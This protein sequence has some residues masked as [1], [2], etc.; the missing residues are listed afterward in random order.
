MFT[1]RDQALAHIRDY[2]VHFHNCSDELKND[3]SFILDAVK[4]VGGVLEFARSDFKND[5][6]IVFEAI[7]QDNKAIEFAN[8]RFKSDEV[9]VTK[10]IEEGC[11]ILGDITTDLKDNQSIVLAHVQKYSDSLQYASPRLKANLE[12]IKAAMTQDQY[13]IRYAIIDD[14]NKDAY[15]EEL[16]EIDPFVR[17]HFDKNDD[18]DFVLQA[19]R[20]SEKALRY[21]SK[22]LQ[23]NRYFILAA[24]KVNGLAL[25][26]A[27]DEFKNDKFIAL[28]AGQQNGEA[29]RYVGNEIADDLDIIISSVEYNPRWISKLKEEL[30]RDEEIAVAAAR[31]D[32]FTN[33]E[34]S[35]LC[36]NHRVVMT[37]VKQNGLAL[38]HGIKNNEDIVL[39][40]VK[41]N[42]EAL[43]YAHESLRENPDFMRKVN[44]IIGD[45]VTR[46]VSIFD[47]RSERH[48][49]VEPAVSVSI[50]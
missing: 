15:I 7:K 40:A 9:F 50:S 10:L 49:S 44:A 21:A 19:I 13:A 2:I 18:E 36:N 38:R 34:V 26:F 31:V 22:R 48:V 16:I 30:Y 43:Q 5:E 11:Y 39:E 3:R 14:S 17:L 1:D 42:P 46:P 35:P 29:F 33:L 37:A 32:G 28:R 45:T 25:K 27:I 4:L 23:T 47:D 6:E 8:D 41:Q 20:H 12:I 24:V